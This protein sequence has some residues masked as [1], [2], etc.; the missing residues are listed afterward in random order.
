M[1]KKATQLDLPPTWDEM[2]EGKVSAPLSSGWSA[3]ELVTAWNKPAK[4]VLR[5]L[6]EQGWVCIGKRR[7]FA[8]SGDVKLVP[9][10][11]PK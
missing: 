10:Y 1:S 6:R 5:A 3:E 2:R 9:I 4:S 8:I 7:E 11:A